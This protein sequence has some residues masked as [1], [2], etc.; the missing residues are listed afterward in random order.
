MTI[1]L[2]IFAVEGVIFSDTSDNNG[3]L[4]KFF[5]FP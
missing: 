5:I 4:I 3:I 2:S 1:T